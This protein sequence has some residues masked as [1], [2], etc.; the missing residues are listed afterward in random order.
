MIKTLNQANKRTEGQCCFYQ[1]GKKK[2]KVFKRKDN[3]AQMW[4]AT[5]LIVVLEGT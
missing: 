3:T 2:K 5:I 4:V 1:E